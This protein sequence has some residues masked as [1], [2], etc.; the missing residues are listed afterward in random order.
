M[1]IGNGT[2]IYHL[3]VLQREGYLRSSVSGNRKL[4]WVKRDFPGIKSAALTELQ[5]KVVELLRNRGRMARKELEEELGVPASTLH[6]HLKGL[7][8]D[9]TLVEEKEGKGHFCS[10]GK[11]SGGIS[12]E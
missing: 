2:T 10:L 3:T 1:G 4:F 12:E 6:P 9:G 11:E 5:R 7:A 8:E